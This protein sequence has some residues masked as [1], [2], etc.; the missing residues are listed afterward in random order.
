MKYFDDTTFD[1]INFTDNFPEKGNYENCLFKN[2]DFSGSNLSDIN[3][4]DCRFDDCNLSLANITNVQMNEITFTN[5]KLLGLKFE[6]CNPFL[7]K[8]GF[9]GCQLNLSSF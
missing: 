9:E 2:C 6:Y 5:C 4:T 1:K 8:V 7:F 3:F